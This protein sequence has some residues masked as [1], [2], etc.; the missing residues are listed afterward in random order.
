MYASIRIVLVCWLTLGL[1]LLVAACDSGLTDSATDTLAD[2]ALARQDRLSL[3]HADGEDDHIVFITVARKAYDRHLTDD[4]HCTSG[5]ICDYDPHA[6]G[7]DAAGDS[8]GDGVDNGC[9]NCPDDANTDQADNEGDGIGDACDDDDDNDGDTDEEEEACGSDPL[10][11]ADTCSDI[12]CTDGNGVSVTKADLCGSVPH[13][14]SPSCE[15]ACQGATGDDPIPVCDFGA[16]IYAPAPLG[17][18]QVLYQ[19]NPP[20]A[21]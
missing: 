19:C 18:G 14:F 3:C 9:D 15:I 12:V 20:H 11:P 10:D 5:G 16:G 4:Q 1:A 6:F 8:D 2:E 21:M 7:D 17:G 13:E